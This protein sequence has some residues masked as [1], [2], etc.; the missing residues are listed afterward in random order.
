MPW[1]MFWPMLWPIVMIGLVVVAIALMLRGGG[2]RHGHLEDATPTDK[3]R[4]KFSA[5]VLRA[6][7]LTKGNTRTG[8]G[9]CLNLEWACHP[10]CCLVT[11]LRYIKA[12][13]FGAMM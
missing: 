11:E 7:R 3:R 5:S 1:V 10:N 8:S 6:A 12:H 13:G 4:L 2:Q 9:S